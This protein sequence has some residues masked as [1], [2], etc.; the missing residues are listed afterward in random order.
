MSD[1]QS[2]KYRLVG[3]VV[4]VIGFALLWSILLDHDAKRKVKDNQLTIPAQTFNVERFDIKDPKNIDIE[5]EELPVSVADTDAAK[6]TPENADIEQTKAGVKDSVADPEP[7]AKTAP[8]ASVKE[9]APLKPSIPAP[10]KV[11]E[12]PA[13]K[14]LATNDKAAVEVKA[15][16]SGT[17]SALDGKGLPEAWVLQ[18]ASVKN[19]DNAQ[20][21]QKKLIASNFPAYIKSATTAD[22]LSYRVLVGPKLSREK[23][24]MMARD[25]EKKHGIKGI[26]V[27]FQAAYER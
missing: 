20:E 2:I 24:E 8:V 3:A 14:P 15:A 23:A 19:K 16:A 12:A 5:G 13:P 18:L 25:I 11:T 21:L 27:R 4:I 7:S 1:I 10:A 9:V 26:I 17:Y 22:G 6:P